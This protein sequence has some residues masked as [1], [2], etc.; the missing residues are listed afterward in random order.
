MAF[1]QGY[2]TKE[3]FNELNSAF[4][5]LSAMIV[6]LISYLRGSGYKGEK[7]KLPKRKSIKEIRKKE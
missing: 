3:Q 5:R 7:Y 2:I 6:H 1:G 4:R